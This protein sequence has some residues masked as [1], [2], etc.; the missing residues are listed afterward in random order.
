MRPKFFLIALL[1]VLC[2]SVA[3]SLNAQTQP[4]T[5][6]STS[7]PPEEHRIGAYV[8]AG[9][10]EAGYR[11]SDVSGAQFP[12]LSN[13]A[14][15]CNYTGV[16]DTFVD[17]REGPRVFEQTLSLRS[18]GQA[19][20]LFDNLFVSSFGWGG[21]P[22][23][24]ARLRVSK[25]KA[26]DFSALF[27]RDYQRFDYNILANPLNPSNSVP[28]IPIIN[29]PHAFDT[30]RRMTDINLTLAPQS[31]ISVRLGYNRSRI[32]G[33]SF[34]SFHMPRGT[35]IQPAVPYNNTNDGFRA[36]VDLK[37]LPRTTLSFDGIVNWYKNDTFWFLDT[38]PFTVGGIPTNLGISWNVAGRQPCAAPFIADTVNPLCNQGTFFT[39]Q[40]RYR[41]TSPTVT[42]ALLS[43]YWKRLDVSLRGTYGWGDMDSIFLQDWLGV[44]GTGRRQTTILN[45][46]V[47]RISSSADVGLTLHLS[48]HV[49]ISNTFRFVNIRLPGAALQIQS[50]FPSTPGGV[51]DPLGVPVVLGQGIDHGLFNMTKSNETDLELDVGRHAGVNIGYRYTYRRIQ[52]NG[53]AFDVDATTGERDFANEAEGGFDQFKIPEHAAIGGVWFQPS[54]MFRVMLD[55]EAASAGITY[56]T[57]D[58]GA[59]PTEV[60]GFTTFTR[61]TPRHRQQYRARATFQPERHVSVSGS[62]NINEQR[63]SLTNLNYR[64]HNRYYSFNA[65]VSP[66][67]RILLDVAYTYQDVLQND[68]ICFVAS[69]TPAT[70][71]FLGTAVPLAGVCP[72]DPAY[73]TT[74]GDYNNQVH[75]GSIM[76]RVKPVKRVTLSTGYSIISNDGGFTQLNAL[77]PTGPLQFNYHRPLAALEIELAKG[78]AL[79]GGYNYYG[80]NE[81]G[82]SADVFGSGGPTIPRDFHAN[83][84]TIALRYSF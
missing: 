13:T 84:G 76:L 12:C 40:D 25:R 44:T 8:A 75:Y 34:A 27:R 15:L 52:L 10:I 71:G 39:R 55:A 51:L 57:A 67:D 74:L 22:E 24:V 59:T 30:V 33:S 20:V 62:L 79:K 37:F 46:S 17:E 41:T 54:S 56:R 60:T 66:N 80:Y 14:G 5:G 83:N 81:K 38:F 18:V 11:F 58:V 4:A 65:D 73:L 43:H 35:D 2:V 61:I 31:P 19:G 53:E 78:L 21:D 16:Y 47:K 1:S 3:V 23:N 70:G 32:Q 64:F 82:S 63:N 26:Y 48:D 9:S 68:L 29:S 42:G 28:N 7:A 45:P 77:Q 72:F 6:Q 50:T 36:G 49:R 69:G